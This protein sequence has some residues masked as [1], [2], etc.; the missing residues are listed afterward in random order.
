MNA[1]MI[2]LFAALE[3][4]SRAASAVSMRQRFADDPDRFRKFSL[5]VGN[6]LL[7]YSKNLLDEPT[8]E[9][10]VA[11]AEAAEVEKYRAR[12]FSG[13]PINVTEDRPALHVALRAASDDVY[14]VAG[15]NVVPDVHAVLA[16]MSD[17][18][19]G[20]RSGVVA[21]TGGRFADVV[22]IG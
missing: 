21:G 2:K 3:T 8:M 12:M 20:V 5:S 22:N 11:L 1:A 16:R 17:F 15:R 6:V 18:A 13:E 4:Q 19:V 7:D 9:N 14:R 10:L